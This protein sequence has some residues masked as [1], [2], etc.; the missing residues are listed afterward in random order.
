MEEPKE[1]TFRVDEE[2]EK[3]VSLNPERGLKLNSDMEVAVLGK[4][5]A[6]EGER[7]SGH[8]NMSSDR[9]DLEERVMSRMDK[10]TETVTRLQEMMVHNLGSHTAGAIGPRGGLRELTAE[11]HKRPIGFKKAN[12]DDAP[13]SSMTNRLNNEETEERDGRTVPAT[14]LRK[15]NEQPI[16][17]HRGEILAVPMATERTSPATLT[18]L[19]KERLRDNTISLTDVWNKSLKEII[20]AEE[21][22]RTGHDSVELVTHYES[23]EDVE[24]EQD[25]SSVDCPRPGGP[26][27]VGQRGETEVMK[28]SSIRKA[29]E[30]T[31]FSGFAGEL[32][33]IWQQSLK[34]MIAQMERPRLVIPTFTGESRQEFALFLQRFNG[35]LESNPD[36]TPYA[37]LEMLI[38]ACTGKLKKSLITYTQLKPPQKGYQ[39]AMDMLKARLGNTQDHMDE[40]LRNLQERPT[41]KDNDTEE[42]QRLI[43]AL[44]DLETELSIAGRVAELNNF[45]MVMRL[46]EKLRGKLRELYDDQLLKFKTTKNARP[47][48]DWFRNLMEEH[49][50]KL[51]QR[52]SMPGEGS[53]GTERHELR[54]GASKVADKKQG[55]TLKGRAMGFA[56]TSGSPPGGGT[57]TRKPQF[58][59]VVCSGNH[60]LYL[61]DSFRDLSVDERWDVVTKNKLCY[62]CLGRNHLANG[63]KSLVKGCG[64]GGCVRSHSRWLHRPEKRRKE[65]TSKV[66]K[67]DKRIKPEQDEA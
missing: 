18:D 67:P 33:D 47:G 52:N 4:A 54:S 53:E 64:V 25:D 34:Q 55:S 7:S 66:V 24:R 63:C 56:S 13:A 50:R 51:R 58:P 60:P 9:N 15:D 62:K 45:G 26:S 3:E 23:S 10:L 38:T 44:W 14:G 8:S 42:I 29:E 11:S 35:Y 46:A 17:D 31:T 65:E 43:D 28:N 48:I 2:S 6:S 20:T 61:C 59:C 57:V 22:R 39:A 32:A 36:V 49:V 16:H 19:L 37:R 30:P 1:D 40:A 5:P 12:S 21:R 41:L 27:A